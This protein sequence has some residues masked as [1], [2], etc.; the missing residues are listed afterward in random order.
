MFN[1]SNIITVKPPINLGNARE[2][3]RRPQ[4]PRQQQQCQHS[5]R[6]TMFDYISPFAA[7]AST[8]SP[9]KS[10]PDSLS[11]TPQIRQAEVSND[12]RPGRFMGNR[13]HIF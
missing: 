1:E 4:P 7:L 3:P 5:P 10:K 8:A 6:K 12:I 9:A 11:Q 13:V 2:L